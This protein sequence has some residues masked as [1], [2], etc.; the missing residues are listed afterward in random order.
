MLPSRVPFGIPSRIRPLK[1]STWSRRTPSVQAGLRHVPHGI[2]G[3]DVVPF[4]LLPGASLRDRM[5]D[6]FGAFV[7]RRPSRA[8]H[9]RSI[10]A[11]SSRAMRRPGIGV[12]GIAARHSRVTPSTTF[13]NE[14][15]RRHWFDPDGGGSAVGSRI[16]AVHWPD[17]A[18][19]TAAPCQA[20]GSRLIPGHLPVRAPRQSPSARC[21]CPD[22]FARS[23]MGPREAAKA[24]FALKKTR[25]RRMRSGG[26]HSRDPTP[27]ECVQTIIR[28]VLKLQ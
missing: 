16:D 14:P 22:K 26:R 19:G 18:I 23:R 10:G 21:P 12:P 27:R 5:R 9:Y 8:C 15:S 3:R 17:P 2:S 25:R 28:K 7:Q 11:V 20:H 4:G 13:R 1:L 24:H 6:R